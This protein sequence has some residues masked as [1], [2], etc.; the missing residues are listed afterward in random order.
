MTN[1][2]PA[3]AGPHSAGGLMRQARQA[4][5]LHIAALA[6]ALKVAPAK[7]EALESDRLSDLPDA[8]FARAL[9]KAVCRHLRIEAEP[10][11]A[12]MPP[13]PTGGLAHVHE[14]INA[15]Y[16]ERAMAHEPVASRLR[17]SPLGWASVAV[18]A[19]AAVVMFVPATFW[20]GLLPATGGG[21]PTQ[22]NAPAAVPATPP[23]PVAV[24]AAPEAGPATA[25][26][27]SAPASSTPLAPVPAEAAS[28]ALRLDLP[29]TASGPLSVPPAAPEAVLRANEN[30]W[31][32]VT[33]A[34]GK[35]L[36]A[37][38]VKAGDM[39]SL[40]GERPMKVKIGNAAGAELL[41]QGQVV[42]IKAATRDNIARLELK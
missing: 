39:L 29:A 20:R 30:T 27:S 24:A 15:P 36:L 28:T 19:A 21:A 31:V 17:G 14:G 25:A 18:V 38:T 3:A 10:V 32:E 40:V 34:Q 23:V 37:R 35:T 22:A 9:A 8:T 7:L 16:R 1:D 2:T 42:D 41:D 26:A 4:Q 12:L 5:G 33:D 6:A 11:L 13:A